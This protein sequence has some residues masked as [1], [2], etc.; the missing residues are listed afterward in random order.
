MAEHDNYSKIGL[1]TKI[2]FGVHR[3]KNQEQTN[4]QIYTGC[5]I[6][7]FGPNPYF[8]AKIDF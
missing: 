3:K 5:P 7:N 8:F 1:W 2:K 6:I 4:K